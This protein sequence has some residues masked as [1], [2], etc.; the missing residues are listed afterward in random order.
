MSPTM[1]F[2]KQQLHRSLTDYDVCSH[3]KSI[4][5]AVCSVSSSPVKPIWVTALSQGSDVKLY[6]IELSR[7]T[8]SSWRDKS[9]TLFAKLVERLKAELLKPK[10]VC[11]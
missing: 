8:M 9:V 7:Q 11:R 6:G 4:V 3:S 10:I 5:T 1:S 2:T